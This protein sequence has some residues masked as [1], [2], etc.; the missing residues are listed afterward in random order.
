M[1]GTD[2][3]ND[4]IQDVLDGVFPAFA[5]LAGMQL[6]LFSRL[7]ESPDDAAGLAARLEVRAE[8]LAPLLYALAVGGWLVEENGTFKNAEEADRRLVRG[9]PNYIGDKHDLHANNW[10]RILDTAEMIRSGGPLAKY[11]YHA[12]EAELEAILRGLYPDAV[13]DARLLID[14]FDFSD[15]QA[16]LDVGG[17]SGGLAITLVAAYP[18]L[19]ATVLDLPSVT[20]VTARF[21]NEAGLE[22]R[23][24]VAA[25]DAISEPIRGNYDL[26]FAR[27]LFQVLSAEDN[28]ALLGNLAG[29]VRP[30]GWLFVLGWVLDDARTSPVQVV[31]NNLI[32]LNAYESGQAYT[33]STYRSWLAGAGFEGFERHVLSGGADPFPPASGA[34]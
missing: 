33:E 29:A 28:Q 10:K 3:S 26:V 32:L 23:V 19:R 16:A 5:L 24:T 18:Q 1:A 6:D 31:W 25:A 21:I 17:G 34:V 4:I 11:D 8:K 7:A 15:R 27:H 2:P 9:R 20:P 12:G 30:G 22:D 14:R 13:R